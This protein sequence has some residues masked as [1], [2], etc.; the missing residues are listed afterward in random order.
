MSFLKSL[1]SFGQTPFGPI[2]PSLFG[3]GNGG[4]LNS[5]LMQMQQQQALRGVQS[6]GYQQQGL[7]SINEGYDKALGNV[8]AQGLASKMNVESAG[9]QTQA[10]IGQNLGARGLG[11]T[12][13]QANLGGLAQGQTAQAL[14]G[15]DQAMAGAKA[16]LLTQ[17]GLA[18][19]QAY[20]G[21]S[22]LMQHLSG[23]E[24]GLGQMVWQHMAAQPSESQQL[25]QLLGALGQFL[26]MLG[27][28][29]GMAM[30]GMARAASGPPPTMNPMGQMY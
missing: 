11:N 9:A 6:L 19:N 27:G 5:L 28:P 14:A 2:G 20:S 21:L 15:I 29:P 8:G 17:K 16:N 22:G 12:T 3:G 10:S 18:Q 24:T 4:H 23:N 7:R 30:A 26:P 1:T 25:M 13:V